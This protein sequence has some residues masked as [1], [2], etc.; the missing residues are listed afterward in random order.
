ME[1]VLE[2]SV[3]LSQMI[4][5]LML[6]ARAES[7][8]TQIVRTPLDIRRELRAVCEFYEPAAAEAGITLEIDARADR[9]VAAFDRT[10]FQRVLGNLMANALT[11]TPTRGCV[12][13]SA[14][15]TD[16][17]VQI[18]VADTG[19]GI[20]A[21]RLARVSDRFY[22]VDPSRSSASGGLGL[23]LA[24]VRSIV[25]V[26]G[27]S[28]LIMSECGHGTTVSGF[29]R[30]CGRRSLSGGNVH[31]LCDGMTEAPARAG[32]VTSSESPHS[33]HG[34]KATCSTRA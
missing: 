6:L 20:P 29:E 26:H 18:D 16:G 13:L 2:E 21:E 7:P 23:G 14:T 25:T 30:R 9:L 1:S 33:F 8:E 15:C 24:I 19:V 22:R 31:T 34:G 3:R 32:G 12:R 17:A 28:M 27:G 11:H 10:L 4:D 5:G